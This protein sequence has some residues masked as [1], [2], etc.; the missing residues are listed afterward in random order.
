MLGSFD[1]VSWGFISRGLEKRSFKHFK[2]VILNAQKQWKGYA[3]G[4]D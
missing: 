1:S 4:K 2:C 3:Q